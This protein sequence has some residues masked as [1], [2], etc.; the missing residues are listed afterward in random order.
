MS[1]INIG[2]VAMI[3]FSDIEVGDRARKEMGDLNEMES[4]IKERGL[5]SPLAVKRSGPNKYFLLAGERRYLI[6]Q[7]NNVETIPVRI[8]PEDISEYEM[9]SIELAENFY[10][11]DF[12]YW[13][14]DNLVQEAHILQQSIHGEKAPGPDQHGWSTEDTGNMVGTSKSGVSTAI[15][16][17]E[18]REAFP[19]LFE[20]CK[21]QYDATKVIK[22]M[23]ELV[24][25]EVIAQRLEVERQDTS[26]TQLSKCY[27]LNDFFNGVKEIPDNV[28]HLVEIDPPYAIDIKKAKKAD[29]DSKY[30]LSDY[31]EVSKSIYMD[32]DPETTWQ[33]MNATFKECYRVMTDHSWL[34]CWF[35]PEPWFES[36]YQGILKAGFNTTRMCGIWT[37]PSG[38][39]KRPEIH[40]ANSYEMFFY[41]WKGRPA[42]NK[43]GSTNV[44]DFP[45]VPAQ[46][47]THPTERPVELTTD[48]YNTFA[49]PGSRVLIPFLGSGNGII[50]AAKL[51]MAPL[52]FELG[53]SHRDSFLIKLH[54][55]K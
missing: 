43:A 16:R 22:K 8:Y 29:G 35:A 13:E 12:E 5:I 45:P 4:S 1:E 49:F 11:K 44:F 15:K 6:L 3:K 20:K 38:Q 53:K 25:K 33:G 23:D 2:E 41:A 42:L 46:Q 24:V 10:R 14:F 28:Y 47:K 19:E 32:G 17:A 51:G 9:K 36:I 55:M 39:S 50:S 21:T 37:K 40:L 30:N 48:I 31:N 54:N 26:F 7:K 18:A 27:I 34:I 52:G